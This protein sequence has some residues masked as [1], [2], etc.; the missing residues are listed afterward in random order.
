MV[1]QKYIE[2]GLT[3][4]MN[5]FNNTILVDKNTIDE[6]NARIEVILLITESLGSDQTASDLKIVY[7]KKESIYTLWAIEHLIKFKFI[8]YEF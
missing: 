7:L 8:N 6:V 5:N 3:G 1:K 2:V 4:H